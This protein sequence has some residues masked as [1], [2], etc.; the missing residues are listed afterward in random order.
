M[1]NVNLVSNI[2]FGLDS[3]HTKEENNIFSNMK[4]EET[5][6]IIHPEFFLVDQEADTLDSKINF[7]NVSIFTRVK[8]KMLRII[9]D[10]I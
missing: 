3:T 6:E 7:G 4:A 1:P 9:R 10:I 2:G 8:N 5:T